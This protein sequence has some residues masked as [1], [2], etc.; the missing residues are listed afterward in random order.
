METNLSIL[1][2]T[3]LGQAT[4]RQEPEWLIDLRK[5]GFQNIQAL[6][7]PKPDKTKIDKWNFA[8]Q[9]EDGNTHIEIPAE[10]KELW[11][12]D[13]QNVLVLYKDQIVY[14]KTTEAFDQSGVIFTNLFDGLKN[15][16]ELIQNYFMKKAIKSDAHK[17][18]ALHTA[19]LNTGA[20]IYVPK[21][22]VVDEPVHVVFLQKGAESFHNHVLLVADTCSQISYV[23]TTFSVDTVEAPATATICAEIIVNDGAKVTY[24]AIDS[25]GKNI[26]AYINRQAHV[27]RDGQF[28][29]AHGAF[30][31]ANAIIETVTHL[32]GEASKANT[33]TVTV[34]RE[35]QKQNFTVQTIHYGNHSEGFIL[36]HGV[37]M[38]ESVT[39][40]NGIG[41]IEFGAVKSDAQQSS[42]LL[43]LNKE[44]RGDA[45][46][47]LLIDEHDVMAGHAASVGKIDEMQMYYLMS[48]GLLKEEAE[49]LIIHGFLAPVVAELPIEKVR[50]LLVRMIEGKVSR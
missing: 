45:N 43:M 1:E 33:R 12:D 3:I 39:I 10:M 40:F 14:Q 23:E 18:T 36:N 20:F 47:I 37:G 38:E 32:F 9:A 27:D 15:H 26:T 11:E 42:K 21:N 29:C 34:G 30:G 49:R 28:D 19:L 17:L 4:A 25:L 6:S 8:A 2:S 5:Q 50:D 44:A 22:V 41:K 7:L 24:G 35:N 31:D 16:N 48:R 46:P 13:E